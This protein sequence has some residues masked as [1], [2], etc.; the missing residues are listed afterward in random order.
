MRHVTAF[1]IG[2]WAGPSSASE[3]TVRFVEGAPKDRFVIEAGV[4]CGVGPAEIVI[5]MADTA[6]KLI[7]DVTA[8]GAGVQVFQPLEV[9]AGADRLRAA[10][11]VRDGDRVVTLALAELGAAET[12]AFTVD[13]DDTVGGREI[14]VEDSEIL[15]A[16]VSLVQ[17][18]VT[19]TAAFDG[20]A[21][22]RL[23]VADCPS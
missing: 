19:W 4:A 10:P 3:L 20:N 6:G 12:M 21:E 1:A 13:V 18:G 22:A 16:T 23:T 17:G 2:L 11:V 14:T 5:D 8:A 9:V 7:F 15:G